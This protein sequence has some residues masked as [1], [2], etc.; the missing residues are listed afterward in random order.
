MSLSLSPSVP[1][2]NSDVNVIRN[3]I[4]ESKDL[5][6]ENQ[7]KAELLH[8]LESVTSE[9]SMEPKVVSNRVGR[10]LTDLLEELRNVLKHTHEALVGFNG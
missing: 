6:C 10:E 3:L 1:M 7:A 2:A 5:A 8:C 4:L 9:T